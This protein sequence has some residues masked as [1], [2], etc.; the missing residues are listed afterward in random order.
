MTELL[1]PPAWSLALISCP[2]FAVSSVV[3]G[4][5][6]LSLETQQ[7]SEASEAG[8]DNYQ[9]SLVLDMCDLHSLL[10]V[11]LVIAFLL[12]GIVRTITQRFN[13]GQIY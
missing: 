6:Y 2:Q 12:D 8:W 5:S 3:E 13:I 1:D 11:T 9:E 7:G 10:E 4:F